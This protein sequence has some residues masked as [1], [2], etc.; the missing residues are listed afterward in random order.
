MKLLVLVDYDNLTD[1]QKLSFDRVVET[2]VIAN[3]YLK[4]QPRVQ[5]FVRIYGGWYCERNI[6]R[7]GEELTSYIGENYPR[8]VKVPVGQD[9]HA[10]VVVQMELAVSMLEDPSTF[11]Y[12][13]YRKKARPHN[14]RVLA[15]ADAGC[16]EQHC[17]MSFVKKLLKTGRC[18]YNSCNRGPEHGLIY[19][20]EQKLV[21][22]M[23]TCDL[24]YSF[25][26]DYDHIILVSAD[27]DFIP[28]LRA[29]LLRARSLIRCLPKQCDDQ[30]LI[31]T[32]SR[33]LPQF[34]L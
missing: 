15:P 17:L 14:V 10:S 4:L 23:I 9:A 3:P 13:T 24:Y 25:S 16:S 33:V 2:A 18:T 19:R 21:D 28:P 6:T 12:N 11:L 32:G 34:S 5:C 26:S 20:N 27:D 30:E 7:S 22:A 8:V 29:G 1:L 31:Q